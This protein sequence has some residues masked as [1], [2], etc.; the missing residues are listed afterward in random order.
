MRGQLRRLLL[1]KHCYG[2][3]RVCGLR[4]CRCRPWNQHHALTGPVYRR[5]GQASIGCGINILIDA[6]GTAGNASLQSHFGFA[7]M[8]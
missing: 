5:R 1:S 7:G 3:Y 2:G 6:T 4:R 8:R